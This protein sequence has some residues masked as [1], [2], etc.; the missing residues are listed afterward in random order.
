[1][2]GKGRKMAKPV[3]QTETEQYLPRI[4]K[5]QEC[6]AAV[7]LLM[8]ELPIAP[9]A[10]EATREQQVAYSLARF[11]QNGTIV[12]RQL[13]S[14]VE[15]QWKDGRMIGVCGPIRFSLEYWAAIHFGKQLL[16]NYLN[17]KNIE[18]IEHKSARLTF[19]GKTPVKL[20]WGGTTEHEAYSV[21]NFIDALF[22]SNPHVR[23][24]YNFLSEATHPNFLQNTYYLMAGRGYEN[25]GNEKFK[26]YAHEILE[27]TVAILERVALG[28]ASEA[29][30]LAEHAL[31]LLP[32]T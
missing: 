32:K 26:K 25:F 14:N 17:D 23:D 22:K 5:T 9:F 10:K 15:L 4:S 1:M 3:W 28:V 6:F 18:R 29:E 13:L 8:K 7:D 16:L 21:M 11:A 19:S 12:V 30:E 24:D 2:G 27:Q 20:P 31:P